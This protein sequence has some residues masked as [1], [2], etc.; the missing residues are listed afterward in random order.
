MYTVDIRFPQ[1]HQICRLSE[2]EDGAD[3]GQDCLGWGVWKTLA[4]IKYEVHRGRLKA[5]I[6]AYQFP[7]RV[8]FPSQVTRMQA[9]EN[10][11]NQVRTGSLCLLLVGRG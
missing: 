8:L 5:C 4:G 7:K 9:G 6:W 3:H 10:E 1:W 11:G 2:N